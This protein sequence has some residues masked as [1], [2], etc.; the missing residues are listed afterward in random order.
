V[1]GFAQS[2]EPL[3]ERS[4]PWN[5]L[6]ISR[7]NE[8]RRKSTPDLSTDRMSTPLSKPC[9]RIY[10]KEAQPAFCLPPFYCLTLVAARSNLKYARL[11][12]PADQGTSRRREVQ[13]VLSSFAGGPCCAAFG[14]SALPEE[15]I[16]GNQTSI[17]EHSPTTEIYK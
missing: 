3:F 10:M 4:K 2:V 8:R 12:F 7:T 1:W 6:W 14:A 11:S 16:V 5:I 17:R 13:T 9:Q 15:T